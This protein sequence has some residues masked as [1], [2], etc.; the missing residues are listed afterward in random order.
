[1]TSGQSTTPAASAASATLS[2][3]KVGDTVSH[4]VLVT[5]QMVL[6]FADLTGDHNPVHT[7]ESYAR[8]TRFKSR[9]AHGLF[10]QGLISMLAGTRLPGPGAILLSNSA[11]FK[12]P[13][14]IGDTVTA[15][16]R[17][18][19]VRSDKPIIG[20]KSLCTNQNGE[21]VMEGDVIVFFEPASPAEN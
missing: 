18:K 16:I 14:H 15:E 20:L 3:P 2:L 6:G 11:K 1:M 8:R 19:S 10:P 5:E 17:V 7:D 12:N 13:I 4:T 9:I 21:T